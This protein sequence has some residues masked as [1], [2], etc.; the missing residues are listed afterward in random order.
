MSKNEE[1]IP[2][3]VEWGRGVDLEVLKDIG[4]SIP[5]G[6]DLGRLALRKETIYP[7]GLNFFPESQGE[8]QIA[9]I[10]INE[11]FNRVEDKPIGSKYRIRTVVYEAF[12]R[13][14]VEKINFESLEKD[15]TDTLQPE[16][17]RENNHI[18]QQ[19]S[20]YIVL[21][22]IYSQLETGQKLPNFEKIRA[23]TNKL[24]DAGYDGMSDGQLL[25]YYY[26]AKEN[27][28]NRFE[29]WSKQLESA[30]SHYLARE[31]IK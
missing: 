9:Q 16:D 1:F 30:K 13:A 3:L 20:R 25:N 6:R 26:K 10:G 5:D 4:Y 12:D 29:F 18:L 14:N 31:Y 15:L 24:M 2:G 27:I 7:A 19:I 28:N 17:I 22:D 21:S 23:E 8:K 11:E